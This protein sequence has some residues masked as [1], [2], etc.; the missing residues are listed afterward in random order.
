MFM[1]VVKPSTWLI[2]QLSIELHKFTDANHH[3]S[4]WQ[5]REDRTTNKN[6]LHCNKK[7]SFNYKGVVV[8]F[9]LTIEYNTIIDTIWIHDYASGLGILIKI[10][11]GVSR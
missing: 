3:W 9:I 4:M 8:C 1:N 7:N 10:I 11:N 2:D 5:T 6:R